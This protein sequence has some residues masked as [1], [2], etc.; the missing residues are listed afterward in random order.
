MAFQ[1]QKAGFAVV[2]DD[3]FDPHQLSEYRAFADQPGIHKVLL[4]PEQETAHARNL[5]R[6]GDDPAREYIDIGIRS[7]YAQ[8]NAS[9]ESLRAAGWIL[10]DT[11]HLSIEETVREILSRS[12][13]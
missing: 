3:F 11:T 7:V 8:L 2:M 1:Y 10:I 12:S 4:L 9:M 6:S 5:K 13:A